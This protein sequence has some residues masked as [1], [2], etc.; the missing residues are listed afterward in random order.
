M[1]SPDPHAD[2]RDDPREHRTIGQK[3][4]DAVLGEPDPDAP[5]D[6]GYPEGGDVRREGEYADPDRR[7]A[8]YPEQDRGAADPA[9]R[10]VDRGFAHRTDT[11]PGGA[12]YGQA[13]QEHG[14]GAT[15]DPVRDDIAQDGTVR[16]ATDRVG[17][18]SGQGAGDLTTSSYDPDRDTGY[19]PQAAGTAMTGSGTAAGGQGG[20]DPRDFVTSS[21]D[22]DR[23][24]GYDPQAA[25]T[26]VS[27]AQGRVGDP[28]VRGHDARGYDPATDVGYVD[29]GRAGT[30][31]TTGHRDVD[32]DTG[33]VDT[34][35][36]DTAPDADGGARSA[37]GA[38]ASAVDTAPQGG[39]TTG[40]AAAG[41]VAAGAVAA[42]AAVA[43]GVDAVRRRGT[44]DR[45]TGYRDTGH[46]D[47]ARFSAVDDT[48]S[49][50]ATRTGR[51]TPDTAAPDTVVS[52]TGTGT[53]HAAGQDQ[54][55]DRAEAVADE[56]DEAGRSE[57][58]ERLVPAD[59]AREYT[60][61]WDAL[62]GDFVDEPRRAVA[63]ADD[64]VGELL[65][66]IQRL[67]ADQRRDL[68]RGFDH[69]R[70]TTEDLRL[71]LRRYRSFFDR[72]LSF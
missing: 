29:E 11:A 42:G 25:G 44:G 60:T 15:P 23:D 33:R 2:R 62:K 70:A 36:V 38:G 21:Y 50:D 4:R 54:V 61:R 55:A 45:D 31:R 26:A 1:T 13:T 64:L 18:G 53:A 14:Y 7:V 71:A 49:V 12:A 17:T 24:T 41:G 48:A 59:R 5:A 10:D 28:D 37:S 68:E 57:R 22:P 56:A 66:E 72:L 19:D 47:D 32:Y 30:D 34:G 3:I 6:R 46:R 16:S 40:G 58:R 69:D 27:D 39:G 9:G 43:A 20:G 65:N 67:F 52:G 51:A 35:R 8:G 63:Q